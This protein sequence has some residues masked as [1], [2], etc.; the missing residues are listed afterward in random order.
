MLHWLLAESA[1]HF[2]QPAKFENMANLDFKNLKHLQNPGHL[3]L[4]ADII[5]G[6]EEHVGIT[7][8]MVIVIK[9][10]EKCMCHEIPYQYYTKLINHLFHVW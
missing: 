10:R 4:T 2:W 8:K 6:R 9:E 1:G 5:Y 7:K 3:L